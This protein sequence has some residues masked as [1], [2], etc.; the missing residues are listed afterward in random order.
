MTPMSSHRSMAMTSG[1]ATDAM[2][3]IQL[4][5]S[6]C[7]SDDTGFAL[8]MSGSP[9]RLRG[10]SSNTTRA[11]EHRQNDVK[12]PL[13]SSKKAVH[14]KEVV[15]VLCD[16]HDRC[17][18][19]V[20]LCVS[21]HSPSSDV[22]Q[23]PPEPQSPPQPQSPSEQQPVHAALITAK[24]QPAHESLVRPLQLERS[25]RSFTNELST[26]LSHSESTASGTRSCDNGSGELRGLASQLTGRFRASGEVPGCD[27]DCEARNGTVQRYRSR[28]TEVSS[29]SSEHH[30]PVNGVTN[31]TT[32]ISDSARSYARG[33]SWLG[34][35]ASSSR[36]QPF[37]DTSAAASK[38]ELTSSTIGDVRSSDKHSLLNSQLDTPSALSS[39]QLPV[40]SSGSADSSNSR[41]YRRGHE[42]M[43]RF[44]YAFDDD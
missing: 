31:G 33:H 29:G 24:P 36:R 35:A 3:G 28:L 34:R 27:D 18:C 9:S 5:F 23:S 39:Q 40:E 32:R 13:S 15:C 42:W 20:P 22:A 10:V 2:P 41:K 14:F 43:G 17:E 12:T 4:S 6:E 19:V 8:K 11:D 16:E 1:V 21:P 38:V 37:V 26:R 25:S 30:L 44:S 7:A